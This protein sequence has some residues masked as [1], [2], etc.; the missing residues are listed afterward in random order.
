MS[1]TSRTF[2]RLEAMALEIPDW[3]EHPNR[4][5][6]SGVLTVLDQA[7]DRAP[8]GAAG[9]RVLLPRSVAERALPSLLGMA[10]DYAPGLR[11][12]DARRKIGVITRAEIS[13]DRLEVSGYFFARDFPEV[14]RDL[15]AK[16]ERLGMSYEV[17][18]VRVANAAA[19]VWE[20]TRVVFTGAAILER[21]AAA[22]ESTSLAATGNGET[23]AAGRSE[24]RPLQGEPM[25]ENGRNIELI[26]KTLDL[27]AEN[28]RS[29]AAELGNL[30]AAVDELRQAHEELGRKLEAGV[31]A[32]RDA[33]VPASLET[34]VEELT[35]ASQ[36]LRRQHEALRAQA[37]LFSAQVQRKTLPPQVLTLLAKSG[38]AADSIGVNGHGRIEAGVLDR[39]LDGLPVEQR[40]AVKSQLARAG[41]LE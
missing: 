25:N 9:H 12:H 34:R 40:I 6:F 11:G 27:V 15:R 14:V 23:K 29:L 33:G 18:D 38:V 32:S 4:V 28:S 36:E 22:Y 39:A 8:T 2:M 7:S 16:R 24:D 5:P 35:R 17:T 3:P 31:A 1:Q 30:R 19:D 37:E 21:A 41:A 26:A 13:G 20:L 10:V